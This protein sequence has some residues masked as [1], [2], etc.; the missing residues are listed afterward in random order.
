MEL[1]GKIGSFHISSICFRIHFGALLYNYL[2]FLRTVKFKID[3]IRKHK[4]LL[5]SFQSIFKQKKTKIF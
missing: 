4:L 5:A 2:M 1:D 3:V